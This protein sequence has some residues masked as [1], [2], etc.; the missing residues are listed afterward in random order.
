MLNIELIS[1]DNA[2]SVLCPPIYFVGVKNQQ[3]RS[4]EELESPKESDSELSAATGEGLFYYWLS[5]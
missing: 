3:M 4:R 5:S 2:L 1:F